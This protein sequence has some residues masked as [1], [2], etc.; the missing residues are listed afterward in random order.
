M[1]YLGTKKTLFA[2]QVHWLETIV[3][4]DFTIVP[5][6]EKSKTVADALSRQLQRTGDNTFNNTELL[7]KDIHDTQL[8]KSFNTNETS[9]ATNGLENNKTLH[10]EYKSR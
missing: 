7:M 9:F 2:R 1:I 5:I 4:Y 8:S 10:E 6:R 3:V